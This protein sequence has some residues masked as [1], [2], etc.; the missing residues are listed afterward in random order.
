M[1]KYLLDLLNSSGI[2]KI[3]WLILL[4][5]WKTPTLCMLMQIVIIEKKKEAYTTKKLWIHGNAFYWCYL[6]IILYYIIGKYHILLYIYSFDN[7]WWKH[8]IRF[9]DNSDASNVCYTEVDGFRIQLALISNYFE[10]RWRR[11]CH[12]QISVTLLVLKSRLTFNSVKVIY[13]FHSIIKFD[14]GKIPVN[15]FKL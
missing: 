13:P 5:S 1:Q 14:L 6:M 15:N 7:V 3:K 10:P 11:F 4:P 8:T 2:H 9:I 12:A